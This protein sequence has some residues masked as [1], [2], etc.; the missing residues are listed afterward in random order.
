MNANLIAAA[1]HSRQLGMFALMAGAEAVKGAAGKAEKAEMKFQPI[2]GTVGVTMDLKPS[3]IGIPEEYQRELLAAH[4]RE[5][6]V[7][8]DWRKYQPITVSMRPDGSFWCVD[9]QHR[10]SGALL[11]GDID[12]L[13]CWVVEMAGSQEEACTWVA[14]NKNRK[15]VK[16]TDEFKAFAIARHPGQEWLNGFFNMRGLK[17]SGGTNPG[18]NEC[19]G[20]TACMKRLNGKDLT[21]GQRAI[22]ETFN[23]LESAWGGQRRVYS[24]RM[25]EG[26]LRVHSRL[27]EA[28]RNLLIEMAHERLG[29]Y[30]LSEILREA[31]RQAQAAN[32]H[33]L[34][35]LPMLI[36]ERFNFGSRK[37][38]IG[39]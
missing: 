13:P 16:P 33:I 1:S 28:S 35:V 12:R 2:V 17:L 3:D 4:C 36:I 22:T 38:T 26:M 19:S 20:I 39:A 23:I 14:L 34:L 37:F 30:Q 24:G 21:G 7:H 29:R 18:P 25:V 5:I 27:N 31:E 6:A 15:R 11:R 8:W 32:C 9:G 10:L